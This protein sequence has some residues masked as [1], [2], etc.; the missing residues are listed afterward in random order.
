ML[1]TVNN[2]EHTQLKTQRQTT[3]PDSFQAS[4]APLGF[5]FS[6]FAPIR[7]LKHQNGLS[8]IATWT[9][10]K[11]RHINLPLGQLQGN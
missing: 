8:G 4:M 3:K 11:D 5:H 10:S 6:S 2:H 7:L 1:L 9:F